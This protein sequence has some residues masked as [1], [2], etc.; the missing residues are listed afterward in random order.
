MKADL[1]ETTRTQVALDRQD[2]TT[3]VLTLSNAEQL[4]LRTQVRILAN[5]LLG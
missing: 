1:V 3:D 4:A 5:R 2:Y